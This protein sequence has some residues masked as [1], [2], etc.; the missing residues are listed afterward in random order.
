L[1]PPFEWDPYSDQPKIINDKAF[2]RQARLSAK[3]DYLEMLILSGA[4]LPLAGLKY[5]FLQPNVTQHNDIFGVGLSLDKGYEQLDLADELGVNHILLRL[6]LWD[7]VRLA[8]YAAFAREA[9]QRKKSV[10]IN[11]LQDREHIEDSRRLRVAFNT[12]FASLSPFSNEFQIGNAINRIK[13]GFFSVSEYLT[14]FKI[15]QTV[16]DEKFSNI[17]LLGPSVIDFEYFYTIRALFGS[18]EIVFDRLSCLL[19][20]DRMGSPHARQLGVFN[21]AAKIRL[22]ASVLSMS[23]KVKH[24]G[25]YVTEVNWPIAGTAPYAP[26]SEKECVTIDK[27]C[28]YMRDYFEIAKL[29][30][31]IS[32]VYWHQLVAPGYGLVD[33]RG[34]GMQKT[35]AFYALKDAVSESRS[36]V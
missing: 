5:P 14:F 18:E 29:S 20:V 26:T 9:C 32:R 6:P 8:Q 16:R 28:V 23:R 3:G 34:G 24:K 22:L 15:A 27:Y 17:E 35:A 7:T 1:K 11:I 33:D 31:F 19:Y 4:V 25:L 36:S 21:T 13:W 12:V 2:K 30:G 10:L